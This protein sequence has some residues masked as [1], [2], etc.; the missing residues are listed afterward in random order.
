[1]RWL[2]VATGLLCMVP[3][4]VYFL[5]LPDGVPFKSLTQ[6]GIAQYSLNPGTLKLRHLLTHVGAYGIF[7]YNPCVHLPVFLLGMGLGRYKLAFAERRRTLSARVT[8]HASLLLMFGLLAASGW[9]PHL[10]LHNGLIAVAF[11]GFVFYVDAL[12]GPLNRLISS[13]A[14]VLLGE[15]S[16]GVYILQ[17][18]LWQLY[19]SMIRHLHLG[20]PVP[21]SMSPGA[22]AGFLVFLCGTA[23]ITFLIIERPCRKLVRTTLTSIATSGRVATSA[24]FAKQ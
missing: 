7:M 11:A 18:P 16:Y 23:V 14:V 22:L 20:S 10:V 5:W 6:A 8:P 12:W 1:L 2:I 17:E 15:A 19:D 24:I 3:P 9:M 4:L 21:G 13:P